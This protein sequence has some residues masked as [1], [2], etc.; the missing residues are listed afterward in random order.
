MSCCN[1]QVG[2]GKSVS[3]IHTESNHALLHLLSRIH[4]KPKTS[5]RESKGEIILNSA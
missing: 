2:K 3:K 1:T 5:G 4:D